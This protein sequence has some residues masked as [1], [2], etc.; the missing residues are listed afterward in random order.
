MPPSKGT[1]FVT[2]Q[3]PV[4]AT[5]ITAGNTAHFKIGGSQNAWIDPSCSFFKFKV[6][7]INT[8]CS[9]QLPACGAN[10]L[11]EN[12]QLSSAGSQISNHQQFGS[13]FATKVAQ[14]ADA[15]FYKGSMGQMMGTTPGLPNIADDAKLSGLYM[16]VGKEGVVIPKSGSKTFA[17][18]ISHH[19]SLFGT[20][21]MIWVGGAN[22]M[23]LRYVFGGAGYGLRWV[24]EGAS[25]SAAGKINDETGNDTTSVVNSDLVI[26]EMTL[27]LNM[28]QLDDS[29][30][31]EVLRAMPEGLC[32]NARG[33]GYF[34]G[35]IPAGSNNLSVNLG[36]GYSSLLELSAV[37]LDKTK[38]DLKF[39]TNTTFYKNKLKKYN[40]VIDGAIV[41]DLRSIEVA[42]DCELIA[43]QLISSGKL[44]DFEGL[45]LVDADDVSLAL[46]ADSDVGDGST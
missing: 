17:L 7:N 33:V 40:L 8:T 13:Y 1:A 9:A 6:S 41:Q 18:P 19:A 4:N 36:L 34:S 42:D 28:V 20:K 24:T 21:Q 26:S 39:F 45:P 29:V 32:Y 23:D 30:Q 2:K 3:I 15:S 5:N 44:D 14:L 11:I 38:D 10:A 27:C 12:I 16:G 25:D 37:Q 35:S 43:K 46:G 31:D 22:S